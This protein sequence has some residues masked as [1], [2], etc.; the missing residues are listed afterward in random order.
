M[1]DVNILIQ[2]LTNGERYRVENGDNSY[3]EIRP[4]TRTS[5]QAARALQQLVQRI[6]MDQQ[7]INRFAQDMQAVMQE[8]AQLRQQLKEYH[9]TK[10][11]SSTT[12]DADGSGPGADTQGSPT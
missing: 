6:D 3:D 5:M 12:S 4:P 2:T 8:N 11:S 7:T 9:E 10:T 1:S